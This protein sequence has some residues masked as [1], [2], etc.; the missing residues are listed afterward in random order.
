MVAESL[1][2]FLYATKNR[3]PP[4][5]VAIGSLVSNR[6]VFPRLSVILLTILIT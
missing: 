6:L 2:D 1:D 3:W 4:L 5:S